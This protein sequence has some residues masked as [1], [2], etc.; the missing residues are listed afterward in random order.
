M[1]NYSLSSDTWDESEVNA[2]NR[3]VASNR[4]TMGKEVKNMNVSLLSL[5]EL[6]TLS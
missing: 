1:I 5:W 6:N 4:Y 2:I 3:V